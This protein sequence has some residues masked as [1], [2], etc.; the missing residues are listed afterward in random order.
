MTE[1]KITL[2]NSHGE[3][4]ADPY[5]VEQAIT[6]LLPA[7]VSDMRELFK[8]LGYQE[9]Y[10]DVHWVSEWLV[11]FASECSEIIETYS[12]KPPWKRRG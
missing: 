3:F 4:T 9:D 11:I 12:F 7:S 6:M 2:V 1:A 5:M 10:S 8:D